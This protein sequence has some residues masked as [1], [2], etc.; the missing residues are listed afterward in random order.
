MNKH[1]AKAMCF[2]GRLRLVLTISAFAIAIPTVAPRAHAKQQLP[3]KRTET[4]EDCADFQPLRKP[5]FGE[6]H[7]H[8]S[9]SIDA[10]SADTR[11]DPSAT[12]SFARGEEI[13]LFPYDAAGNPLRTTQLSRPLDF[14]AVTDHAEGFGELVICTD[15]NSP[16][17][18]PGT[19]YNSPLCALFRSEIGAPAPGA[20]FQALVGAV[21]SPNPQYN[22]A[23]CSPDGVNNCIAE[24]ATVWSEMQAAAEQA[25]DRSSACKFTSFVAYEYTNTVGGNNLHRNIIF[26]NA[27]VPA[28]IPTYFEQ[29]TPLGLWTALRAI[30]QDGTPG[31]DFVSIPHNSNVSGGLMFLPPTTLTE[32]TA[33]A[34]NEPLV[35]IMQQKGESECR[36]G[37]GNTDEQCSF[38][39][40][41]VAK[42]FVNP[43]TP[44]YSPSSYVRNALEQGLV[45]EQLLGVNPFKL[46][47]VGGTD[48]HDATAGATEEYDY[49]GH[50]SSYD[51]TAAQR[52]GNNPIFGIKDNPGGLTVLWAEENSRDALFEAMQRRESYATSGTRPIVRFFGGFRYPDNMCSQAN[53]VKKGYDRG[54]PMG[55]TIMAHDDNGVGHAN[56]TFAILAMMDPGTPSNPGTPLQ[57]VQIIK[58]WLDANGQAQEKVFDVAGDA[59]DGGGVNLTTCN[60]TGPGFDSLCTVWTDPEFDRSQRAFY[61]ARVIEN[62]SCRWSTRLCNEE[63]V[64]CS[65]PASVAPQ[66]AN[67]C[68]NSVPKTIQERAWTSPIWYEPHSS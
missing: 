30:C 64:D 27:A 6:L 26:R 33:R 66:F 4:R 62:P 44:T 36:T 34:A 52:L 37:V 54:V 65:N 1:L 46:G 31:C 19:G 63:G 3:F 17:T 2:R 5:L 10:V 35:E 18:G 32:A 61:Y 38:E 42:L 9:F 43:P 56:P 12:Y 22:P 60:T 59:N 50:L 68:N 48:G 47:F 58:G 16:G 20:G 7:I 53:F 13:G 28:Q 39:Q 51:A 24:G 45:Q 41:D 21:I 67:C 14:T 49:K 15:P 23:V 55:G 57:R 11:N 29:Q 40:L 25:Y 8:T